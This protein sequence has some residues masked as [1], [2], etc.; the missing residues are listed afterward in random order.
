MIKSALIQASYTLA[1]ID[2]ITFY[3]DEN[4]PFSKDDLASVFASPLGSS[5]VKSRDRVP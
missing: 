4:I 3:Q 2:I 5:L 1:S